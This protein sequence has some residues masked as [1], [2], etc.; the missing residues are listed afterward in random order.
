MKLWVSGQVLKNSQIFYSMTIRQVEA[1][2]FLADGP[3]DK[4][5]DRLDKANSRFSQFCERA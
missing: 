5:T 1:E 3:T 2:L 4:W